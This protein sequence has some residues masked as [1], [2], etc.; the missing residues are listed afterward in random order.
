MAWL[1]SPCEFIRAERESE[2]DSMFAILFGVPP[3]L[4]EAIAGEEPD[5]FF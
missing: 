1:N 3:E 5:A 4:V 2:I